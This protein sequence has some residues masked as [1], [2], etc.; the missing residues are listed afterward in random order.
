MSDSE[1]Q[2]TEDHREPT[3]PPEIYDVVPL[4]DSELGRKCPLT[5]GPYDDVDYCGQPAKY[6]FVY[7]KSLDPEDD[8]RG[9]CLACEDCKP[10]V[11]V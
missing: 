5:V 2:P 4:P 10:G 6:V 9:N 3:R 8:S 11:T 1:E 7:E